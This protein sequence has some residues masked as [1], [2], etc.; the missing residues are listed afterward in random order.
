MWFALDVIGDITYS[1]RFGFLDKGEDIAGLL[2]ALHGVLRYGTLAGI[3]ARIHP[4]LFSITAKLGMG[5]AAGRN[6]LMQYVNERIQ[7][8]KAEKKAAGKDVGKT[9]PRDEGMPMDFLEKLLLAHDKDPEKVTPYHVFMMGLSNIIAGSDT[10]AVSLSSILYNLL[11]HPDTLVK[12]RDEIRQFEAEG[13]CGNPNV[14]FKESQ[15]MPY[16]QAVMKEALRIH[17]A[18]GL[19]LWRVVTEGGVEICGTFF[20]DGSIIGINTWCAHYSED[21]FGLDAHVFRPERWLEAQAEGGE[22]LKAMESYWM[23]FGLGSRTCIGRHISFLEMSKLIPQLVR[24]FDFE[25]AH[26]ERPWKTENNWF[27][28]PIDFEVKVS[29]RKT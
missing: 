12:L 21:V 19:P 15:D 24:Q 26:P 6:Y 17:P 8:R 29:L 18:T 4:L 11:K 1:Q 22:R 16:L 20:P 27:V 13:R 23:P 7:Q 5:G 3:Y 14:S 9:G 10:T 25:L 2:K 28:K